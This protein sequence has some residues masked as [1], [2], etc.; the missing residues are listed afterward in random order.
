MRFGMF[1]APFHWPGENPTLALERDL[2]LA[3]L[4]DRLGFHE[5][6]VGE[7]HSG[8]TEIIPAPELFCAVARSP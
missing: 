6:W 2:D 8:G 5:L 1:M 4:L 7:H 3:V